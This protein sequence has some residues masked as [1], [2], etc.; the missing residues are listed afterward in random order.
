MLTSRVRRLIITF[1][2]IAQSL[3][4]AAWADTIV[5]KGG[6]R[7][8]ADSVTERNGR[9]EYSIGDN[10]FTIPKSIVA[11][12]EHGAGPLPAAAPERAAEQPPAVRQQ[13]AVEEKLVERIIHDNQVDTAA[14]KAV[15]A[16][17]PPTKTAGAYAVAA[18]FEQ[19]R[20]GLPASARYLEE[21]LRALPENPI[22]LESYASVLLRLGRV[23]E[24]LTFAERAAR[25]DAQS[26]EAFAI[27]GFAFYKNDRTREA[28][29]AWRKSL[30]LR[31]DDQVKQLLARAERE[32]RTEAEF[33]QDETLHFTLRYEGSQTADG[34]RRQILDTLE[35]GYRDLQ[36]DLNAAPRN[37]FVSLYTDRAF[38]DVTQAPAWSAALND[39]KIRIPISGIQSVTPELARVLRHEL[40]HSFVAQI[41]HGRVPQWLNEGIAEL[42]QGVSTTAFGPRLAALYSAGH[43]IPLNQLEGNFESYSSGEA[44]VAY[45]EALAAVEYIRRTYGMADVARL[46]Q[47]L[48]EGQ[49]IESALRSTIHGGYAELESAMT[50]YLKR[51]YGG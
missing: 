10:S 36:N 30:Q 38:F 40:T 11:R 9:I 51:N 6:T 32:S 31:P 15:A 13:L 21:A 23:Q 26:G 22:L 48:G 12:I 16:E 35:A 8:V 34:L 14:L 39:G 3:C 28:I 17:G 29:T 49:S 20:S 7:I 44:S 42:E 4:T 1:C 46:L 5:L 33:R 24:A 47:R 2:L 27:L 50:E 37:I 25:A 45:A 19:G 43:Q 18:A 41:T